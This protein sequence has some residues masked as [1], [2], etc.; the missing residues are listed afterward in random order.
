MRDEMEDAG[1]KREG[2]ACSLPVFIYISQHFQLAAVWTHK[3]KDGGR[4]RFAPGR[5]G[6]A[7]P[8]LLK[9][10]FSDM[11]CVC[12]GP[13]RGTSLVCC[14]YILLRLFIMWQN[15]KDAVIYQEKPYAGVRSLFLGGKLR[16]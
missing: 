8:P 11:K 6:P 4:R 9:K 15:F 10:V 14:I 5:C 7:A 3:G 12:F 16:L 13:K 2:T 1:E